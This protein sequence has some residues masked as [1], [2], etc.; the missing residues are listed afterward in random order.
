VS[1]VGERLKQARIESGLTLQEVEEQT[2]IRMFYLDAIEA[3]DYKSLPGKVYITGFLRSYCKLLNIDS[4]EI[5]NEFNK[6]WASKKLDKDIVIADAKEEIIGEKKFP[7]MNFNYNK[8]M[9]F[10]ILILAVVVLLV[11]NQLWDRTTPAPPS[12]DP[13]I[14]VN[15]DNGEEINGGPSVS[16]VVYSGVNIVI[17]PTRANC[18]LEVNINNQVAFSGMLNQG[19]DPLVFHDENE[20]RIRLGSA[21]AVD[22]MH[23]GELLEPLGNIGEVVT[24]IFT[25]EEDNEEDESEE[26]DEEENEIL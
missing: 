20:I 23:N 12:Q 8:M 17:I 24:K 15:G 19:D 14:V 25:A 11:V 5:I 4:D 26:N 1:G 10:S 18:W 6:D 21:G 16:E 13:S 7:K 2:K 3:D 22:I 9:R